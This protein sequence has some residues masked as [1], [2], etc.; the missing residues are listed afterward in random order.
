MRSF[1]DRFI[2]GIPRLYIKQFPYS[3]IIFIALWAW[4]PNISIIFLIIVLVG[5]LMLKLQSMAWLSNLRT[6]YGRTDRKFL[7]DRPSIPVARAVRN[8]AI[9]IGLS[10]LISA[11]L[12]RQ[13][14]LNFW[15]LFLILTGF[16][17]TYRDAM[18]FGSPTVYV[19]TSDGI[20][21]Y[22]APGHLDYRLFLKFSEI[23]QIERCRYRDD[24]DWTAF[25]RTVSKNDEGLLLVPRDPGGFSK[26]LKKLFILPGNID[27]FQAQLPEGMAPGLRL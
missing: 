6:T 23:R 10:I 1:F 12:H 20:G 7:V 2:L 15:Q 8:I 13:F 14:D 17:L 3:W 19:A 18:F 11:L 16:S 22:F 5:L 27:Q 9:L 24:L 26:R 25:V 21:V 4:P